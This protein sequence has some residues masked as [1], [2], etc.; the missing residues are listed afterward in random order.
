VCVCVCVC[1]WPPAPRPRQRLVGLLNVIWPTVAPAL[2]RELNLEPPPELDAS[3]GEEMLFQ[4][5]C[6][7]N[8]GTRQDLT[9]EWT[10]SFCGGD[11]LLWFQTRT[12]D[13]GLDAFAKHLALWVKHGWVEGQAKVHP[14][15]YCLSAAGVQVWNCDSPY[16]EKN[17]GVRPYRS[18][19]AYL[20]L[21][22]SAAPSDEL[23]ELYRKLMAS[24]MRTM[25]SPQLVQW[26]QKNVELCT[27]E[28]ALD[29]C[30]RLVA[31]QYLVLTEG[32]DKGP[33]L[34]ELQPTAST[35]NDGQSYTP[36]V[37]RHPEV[38]TVRRAFHGPPKVSLLLEQEIFYFLF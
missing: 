25:T 4:V 2:F 22:L 31:Y 36:A 12:S 38:L 6:C 11:A 13:K 24:K 10:A 26:V 27:L 17:I 1:V 21:A 34:F 28:T 37:L 23:E 14:F 18:A 16:F 5:F 20:K 32:D 15:Y 35:I 7:E 8:V 29:L 9:K 33:R 19:D 30:G 3:F